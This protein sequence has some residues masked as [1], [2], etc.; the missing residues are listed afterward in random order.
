MAKSTE[1]EKPFSELRPYEQA[2]REIKGRAQAE[3]D[4]GRSFDIAASVADKILTA[5]T[6]DEI[7]A[8][9]QQ[10][11]EGLDDF[12]G[13]AFQFVGTL[14][15]ADSA[16]Q[17]REGG[18]GEYVVMKIRT[19]DEIEHMVSTGATNIVFQLKALEN[20]G[21]FLSPDEVT[22]RFFTFGAR[23]VASGTLYWLQ[24]A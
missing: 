18:T 14:S 2:L 20:K 17:Y 19:M 10:G 4:G 6:I 21:M 15:W 11:P 23:S 13:K 16:E 1:V 12:V 24:Y 7:L 8:I 3:R 22:E 9:P 5:E